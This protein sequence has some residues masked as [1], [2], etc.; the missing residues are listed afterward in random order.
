[1]A[2]KKKAA[3]KKPVAK[4]T[5][6][7]RKTAKKAAKVAR[8]KQTGG[9]A[10][11]K[12]V[13][14][15][16]KKAARKSVK[17]AAKKCAKIAAGEQTKSSAKK[18][19]KKVKK[20]AKQ[21]VKKSTKKK[22]VTKPTKVSGTKKT[23]STP[24]KSAPELPTPTLTSLSVAQIRQAWLSYFG[25]EKHLH[26]PSASLI[27][28]GDPSLLFTTAGM[29]QFKPYFSG[30]QTAPSPRIATIQKCLRTTDLE[31][32]GK[33]DRH[34]TFFEMLGNFSFGDYFKEGA[35]RFAWEFSLKELKIDPEKIW[36]TVFESDDEAEEIWHKQIGVPMQRIHRLG[37]A[38]NW[39]GPA[40][41]TGACGP[42][43]ELYFDRG[44]EY[45]KDCDPD[46]CRPGGECDRFMEY[47]NLVFNQFNQDAD[48]KLHPLPRTGIDTGAGLER[49]A[50]LLNGVQ[51]VFD[52]DELVRLREKL[53]E[54]IPRLRQDGK[55]LGYTRETAPAFRVLCDHVR[56]ASF[57]I[58]DGILPGNTGRGYVIRRVIRRAL[59]FAR[60]L[61]IHKPVLHLMVPEVIAIYEKHYPDLKTRGEEITTRIRQEEER[62]LRTLEQG[63]RIWE[64]YLAE[65]Q[66]Q[67]AR[68]FGGQYAFRLYDTFGFPLEM[69]TELAEQ[70]GMEIDLAGFEKEME[71][72]R[73]RAR[74]GEGFREIEIPGE[75]ASIA[76]KSS[77]KGYNDYGGESKL[78]AAIQNGEAVE[79]VAAGPAV[80][81]LDQT[82]FYPEGGGQLG[83]TGRITGKDG[84]VFRV[85]DTRRKGDM[86][87]H[88]G[89]LVTGELKV[90]K[91]V[92]T[93][94]ESERRE[95]LTRHHSATHL[96]NKALRDHLGDHIL[97][98]GSLVAPDY[99][100]FDF[101][102]DKKIAAEQLVEIE[103]SVIGAIQSQGAVNTEVLP[104]AA[105]KKKGAVATF[106]EKYGEKVRVVSMAGGDLSI[107]LCGGCHVR[108]TGD[109]R[110]FHITRET[111]PGAGNRRI[112]AIAGEGVIEHMQDEFAKLGAQLSD[113]LQKAG[114]KGPRL[115][116]DLPGPDEIGRRLSKDPAAV[117]SLGQDIARAREI[118]QKA[119]KQLAKLRKESAKEAAGE[120]LDRVDDILA[121]APRIGE[122]TLV[123]ERFEGV[124]TDSLR[125]LGDALKEKQRNVVILLGTVSEKGPGLLFMANKAAV[126]AGVHCGNLVREAAALIGGGGGGR[127]DMAQAGGK[128]IEGLTDA[129][130]AAENAVRKALG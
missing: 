57:A 94:I 127:P 17:T 114:S 59:L 79:K 126:E 75:I 83:D 110:Y 74:A 64:E 34:L 77:F 20:V 111:S 53:R 65:H 121:Q 7:P 112:E 31:S 22:T 96:L 97:Q 55:R 3:K 40:G 4:K 119:E 48:G 72:Q 76:L 26:A 91:G 29:V 105:A 23:G 84:S 33:T 107:E 6:A 5:T 46:E 43:S 54:L 61:G 51:S 71:A 24:T 45:C 99:L 116:I 1:M 81:I 125:Q 103:K 109:I 80:L 38:D 69:T 15:P 62:F 106:G 115:D 50:A 93:A 92:R 49:I 117:Q 2:T 98:T 86:I 39:W 21:A 8:K 70:A 14:K 130:E 12:T 35:I 30:E 108:N 100:R 10:A 9:K 123:R 19:A 63:I 120:L 11:K 104:I 78:L 67:Q 32:V 73:E 87:L 58:S 13:R 68:V 44:E 41:D 113:F 128:N 47:W 42:C 118:L 56:S 37:K 25:R 89:E 95:G 122:T 90:D 88:I 28:A 124:P 85:D 102:H 18:T 129:L 36:V 82:P 101:S 60:S 27:P 52:T 66:S 16:A